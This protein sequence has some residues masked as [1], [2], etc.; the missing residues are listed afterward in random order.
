M[1]VT[2]DQRV[3][4]IY[5]KVDGEYSL[6]RAR[7]SVRELLETMLKEGFKKAIVDSLDMQGAPTHLEMYKYANFVSNL[8]TSSREFLDM[9]LVYVEIRV[10]SGVDQ[11]G[12]VIALNWGVKI[13]LAESMD[14]ALEI[15]KST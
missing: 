13:H 7:D 4:Y 12:D 11:F 9:T 1:E 14:Q 2:F 3:D 6:D 15:L 10:R 5:V 8:I